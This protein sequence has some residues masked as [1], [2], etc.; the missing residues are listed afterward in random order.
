VFDHVAVSAA[1]LAESER[2]YRLVLS[3]L[4]VEPPHINELGPE[5]DDFALGQ[6][7]PTR[8]PT[9]RL[10]V[11]FV[12]GSRDAVDAFWRAGTEAGYRDDGPPG[13]RPQYGDDY[14]GGFLLDPDG[15]SA[16]AVH[17][18]SLRRDGVVD[19]VWIRVADLES[20]RGFYDVVAEHGGFQPAAP[21]RQR[22]QYRGGRGGSFSIVSGPPTEHLHLAFPVD[23]DG[24]IQGFHRAALAAGHR[25]NGGPG[26]RPQYHPGYYAAFALDPDGN[27]VEL[28][29]HHE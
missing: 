15:N 17:H 25:D 11:G 9:R 14:Y 27:N 10:H 4:G 5:W 26:E 8:R 29:N 22:Y 12:A 18:G 6:A 13:P 23:D 3:A 20:S 24:A 2:F 19:H 28:V 21:R 1:D 7:T 16:E